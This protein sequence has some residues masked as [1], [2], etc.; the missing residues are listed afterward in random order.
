MNKKHVIIVVLSIIVVVLCLGI[1]YTLLDEKTEYITVNVVEN[2]TSMEIPT[3][4]VV[5]SNNSQE[6]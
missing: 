6:M 5:K 1:A 2:G 4:M 3:D